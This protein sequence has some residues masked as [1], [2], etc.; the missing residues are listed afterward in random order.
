MDDAPISAEALEYA[1][2]HKRQI[3]E[4]YLSGVPKAKI[5]TSIFMA[6]SPGAGKT[7]VSKRL[8]KG[9]DSFGKRFARIDADE[10]RAECPG[11][12]GGN[13]HLFQKAATF[14]VHEI[15]SKALKSGVNFILDGTFSNFVIQ[16]QNIER[17]LKRGRNVAVLYVYQTTEVAWQFVQTRQKTEGRSVPKTEFLRK[18]KESVNVTNA[19]KAHFGAQIRLHLIVKDDYGNDK[20]RFTN[21][22]SLDN[23]LEKAYNEHELKES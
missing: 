12:N 14:L 19:I 22:D 13:A 11:Y 3:V 10:L 21:I 2:A 18:S 5:P 7:E 1:K 23:H 6:G 16:S 4:K 20:L 9:L 15:H 8:L 17:S